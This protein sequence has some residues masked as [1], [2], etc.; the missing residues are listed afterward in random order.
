MKTKHVLVLLLLALG[1]IGGWFYHQDYQYRQEHGIVTEVTYQNWENEVEASKDNIPVL[2]YFYNGNAD[3]Y[4]KQN[5]EVESFAWDNA[6][7]V[8]V[9][10]CDVS[11]AENLIIALAHGAIRMPTFILLDGSDVEFGAAGAIVGQEQLENLLR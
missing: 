3:L 2:I 8:K 1:A 9:V 7:K 5:P 10:R 6:G 4:D 11:K